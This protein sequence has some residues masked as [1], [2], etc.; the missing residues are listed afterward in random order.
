[1]KKEINHTTPEHKV[2]LNALDALREKLGISDEAF[3]KKYLSFSHTTY[4]RLLGDKYTGDTEKN[5]VKAK[6]DLVNLRE[7][8]AIRSELRPVDHIYKTRHI[9]AIANS[10]AIARSSPTKN[11]MVFFLAP[12]GG[13]KTTICEYIADKY[14]A[15]VIEA[16]EAWRTSYL[17]GCA[18]IAEAFGSTEKMHTARKAEAGMLEALSRERRVLIIDEGNTFGP[19]TAN[20]LKL[21]L[22]RTET[23]VLVA[24]IPFLFNRMKLG[25]WAESSQLIRRTTTFIHIDKL[26]IKD[27]APMFPAVDDKAILDLI[28][29]AANTFGLYDMAARVRDELGTKQIT[30]Q[31]TQTAINKIKG[32]IGIK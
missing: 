4:Y 20:M 21:I 22:N 32:C 12:T 17:A 9:S 1:M 15:P 29:T 18:C 7:E 14:K 19:H 2:I 10:V 28:T 27:I 13:G 6:N 16:T 30:L 3:A 11:R 25:A 8:L 31:S 24:A 23:V 5:M 26:D